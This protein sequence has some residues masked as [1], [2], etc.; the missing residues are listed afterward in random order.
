VTEAT[1]PNRDLLDP[2]LA[3]LDAV[4]YNDS[5]G[6]F[7]NDETRHPGRVF[8]QTESFPKACLEGWQIGLWTDN[9]ILAHEY[10]SAYGPGHNAAR[11]GDKV[12]D[13]LFPELFFFTNDSWALLRAM[14]NGRGYPLLL[15]NRDSKGILCLWTM[16]DNRNDLCRLPPEAISTVKNY[17]MA[18]FPIRLDGPASV[19]LFAYDNHTRVVE[20]FLP[21]A[22]DVKVSVGAEFTIVAAVRSFGI[23]FPKAPVLP[24]S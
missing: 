19:A 12:E 20:S 6:R 4:S 5:A 16:P 22:S 1:N 3:H 18:G 8:M 9:R 2:L 14:A 13:I 17:V 24:W 21:A 10:S 23:G 11:P 7:V 15:M